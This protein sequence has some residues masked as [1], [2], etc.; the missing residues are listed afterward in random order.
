MHERGGEQLPVHGAEDL[1][2]VQVVEAVEPHV[3]ELDR[4]FGVPEQSQHAEDVVLVHV[5]HDEDV[6]PA[7]QV[8]QERFDPRV[9]TPPSAVHEDPPDEVVVAVFEEQTVAVLRGQHAEAD[10]HALP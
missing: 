10:H 7:V 2:V 3:T 6:D 8:T 9:G 1:P 4:P 5:G